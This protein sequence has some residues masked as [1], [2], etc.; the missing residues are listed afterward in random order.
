MSTRFDAINLG[1]VPPPDV[2]EALDFETI[3]AGM[4]AD[5]AG[6]WPEW[7]ADLESEPAVK[8]LEVAAY[9]ELM[10]RQ[11]VNDAGR[12]VMLPTATKTDLD[13]IAAGFHVA[14]QVIDPG[15]ADA[16]PPRPPVLEDDARLR[17]RIADAFEAL[18]TAGPVGAYKWQARAAHPLV[19]D[20]SVLS[21]VPGDV[22]V[23]ILSAA[24]DGVPSAD[25]LAAVEARLNAEDVRPLNDTVI[26]QAGARVDYAVTATLD[27]YGGPDGAVVL[28]ASRASVQAFVLGQRRLGESVTI[29]GVHKALRV[30]GVRKVTLATPAADIEPDDTGFP[31]CTAVTVGL[32]GA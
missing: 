3:L 5:L 23:T 6:R 7:Q 2:V 14:R 17:E 15:D 18:S 19:A 4:K 12:A 28:A 21:P 1:T 8:I 24:G 13:N 11:R 20:V 26:V 31:Y 25:V 10:L 30:E 9:R 27:V 29:D 32:G 22:L 16:I